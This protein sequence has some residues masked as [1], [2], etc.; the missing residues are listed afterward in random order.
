M[1]TYT[2]TNISPV[3]NLSFC[4]T[5]RQINQVELR[6]DI[7]VFT[8]RI[9]LA[10]YFYEEDED[11]IPCCSPPPYPRKDSSFNPNAGRDCFGYVLTA[12]SNDVPTKRIFSNLL[13][14]EK[15]AFE[16]LRNNMVIT[17]KPADKGGAIVVLNTADYVAECDRQLDSA[18]FYKQL[19]SEPTDQY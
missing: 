14:E 12:T 19:H 10:G 16:E 9:R 8:R 17:I 6:V 1:H 3:E 2:N 4:P 18:S 5:P 7:R 11:N 15:R 13:T